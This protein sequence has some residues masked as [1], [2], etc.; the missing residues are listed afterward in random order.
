MH[1]SDAFDADVCQE[2]GMLVS[3]ISRFLTSL[4][5]ISFS[6]QGYNGFCPRCKSSKRVARITLPYAAKL[7][8]QELM[9]MNIATRYIIEDAV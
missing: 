2:C 1:S 3:R 9:A 7:L 5:L 8:T 4:K 6:L